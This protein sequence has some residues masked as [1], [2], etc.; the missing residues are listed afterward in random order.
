M[1]V[2][3]T[4]IKSKH[5][6]NNTVYAAKHMSAKR[7]PDMCKCYRTHKTHSHNYKGV[8][9]ILW[10]QQMPKYHISTIQLIKLTLPCEVNKWNINPNDKQWNNPVH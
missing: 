2:L 7:N 10:T 5:E 9:F 4:C 6:Q 8:Q 3:P 1:K